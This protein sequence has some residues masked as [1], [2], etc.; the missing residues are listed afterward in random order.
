VR[1]WGTYHRVIHVVVGFLA[2]GFSSLCGIGGG[3]I[4]MPFLSGFMGLEPR[5]AAGTSLATILPIVFAGAVGHLIV[6][7]AGVNWVQLAWF[8]PFCIAGSLVAAPFIRNFGGN[9]LRIA[10]GV[11]LLLVSLKLLGFLPLNDLWKVFISPGWKTV[12]TAL[13]GIVT[14]LVSSLLGVGCGLIMVPFF[15][16]GLRMPMPGAVTASLVCMVPLTLTG[17]LV[18][19]KMRLADSFALWWLVPSAFLGASVGT[20]LWVNI[21]VPAMRT[22]F[23]VFALTMA[24]KQILQSLPVWNPQAQEI[25]A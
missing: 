5:R 7:P 10:F 24:G 8:L 13:F 19:G 21:S 15:V 18:H 1:R 23:A 2:G 20:I 6:S 14:G 11:F 12:W 9:K 16:V 4:L 22:L 3:C 17:A 25:E